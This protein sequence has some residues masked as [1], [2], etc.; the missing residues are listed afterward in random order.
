MSASGL[1]DFDDAGHFHNWGFSLPVCK[2]SGLCMNCVGTSKPLPVLVKHGHLPVVVLSP[3]V[4][5]I[6]CAFSNFHSDKYITL[7]I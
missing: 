2:S 1:T 7:N 3:L 6:R 4:C 5:L